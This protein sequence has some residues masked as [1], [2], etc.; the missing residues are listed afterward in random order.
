MN[1]AQFI[2]RASMC[3]VRGVAWERVRPACSALLETSWAGKLSINPR[4]L[5]GMH[6]P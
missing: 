3:C 5:A 1:N 6:G 4:R 2:K